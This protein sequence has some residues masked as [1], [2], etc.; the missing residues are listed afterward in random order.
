MIISADAAHDARKIRQYNRNRGIRSNIP[1]NRRSWI[2]PKRG[3]PFWF[4]PELYKKRSAIERFFS[5]IEAFKKVTPRYERYE[6]SFLGLI[7]LACAMMIWRI[8]G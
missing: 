3:R 7:R 8:L 1:V 5:W 4:D 2:H 6:H